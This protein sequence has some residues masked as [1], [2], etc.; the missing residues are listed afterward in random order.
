V[1][2]VPP[3][4]W[5]CTVDT[6]REGR[7]CVFEAEPSTTTPGQ[8]QAAANVRTLRQAVPAL[9]AEAAQP[10]SGGASDRALAALCERS[11]VPAAEGCGLEGAVAVVDARGRF[12]PRAR[13]CYRGLARVQRCGAGGDRC[14]TEVVRQQTAPATLACMSRQ[15]AEAC[16]LVVS[17][18]GTAPKG[19]GAA[20]P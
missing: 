11:L 5:A 8:E 7:E 4:A 12:S 13:S 2:N 10:P 18:Q 17:P 3:T 14:Y 6:L 20:A 9:C 1:V 15:C 19:R 16:S